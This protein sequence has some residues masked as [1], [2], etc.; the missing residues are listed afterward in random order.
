MFPLLPFAAGAL[1]GALAVRYWRSDAARADFERA[2]ASLR[3]AADT[4]VTTLKQSAA[5]VRARLT[6][7]DSPAEAAP[8]RK[9]TRR[10]T[11]PATGDS[12]PAPRKRAR[13][14]PATEPASAAAPRR[15]K[16][17]AAKATAPDTR[18]EPTE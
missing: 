12:A 9:T 11:A 15:R 4:G 6:A 17:P 2:R 14:T 18:Q 13:S 5:A 10:K 7:E 8:P 3:S 1:A 16:A